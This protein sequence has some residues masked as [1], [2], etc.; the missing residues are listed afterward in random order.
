[1]E[2][3]HIAS[4]TLSLFFIVLLLSKKEKT[5]ADQ[6]LSVWFGIIFIHILTFYLLHNKGTHLGLILEISDSSAYLHAPLFWFYT[7]ALTQANFRFQWKDGWHF[8]PFLCSALLFIPN[9]YWQFESLEGLR[10]YGTFF[11]TLQILVYIIAIL[12]LLRQ[13]KKRLP[14]LFSSTE[15]VNLNWLQMLAWGLLAIWFISS[16]SLFLF[17]FLNVNIPYFGGFYTNLAISIFVF[18][19]GYFGFRQTTIFAPQHLISSPNQSKAT[20]STPHPDTA[21]K[22]Y[23][24]SGLNPTTA[25]QA[26]QELLSIMHHQQLYLNPQLTLQQL[27]KSLDIP[28]NHLSQIIN[29]Y[30]HLNFFDFVNQYRIEAVK[31]KFEEKVHLHHTLLAIALDCGF[32]SKASF[33]RAFKKFTEMTPTGYLKQLDA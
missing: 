15:K 28:P 18:I 23:A 4:G 7:L 9:F 27:A 5:I 33:N 32:N 29:A 10:T 20:P 17:F 8:L 6:I 12:I 3:L 2:V 16:I 30:A 21:T 13:H 25:E 14:D 24:K 22:K 11:K 26:F 1:M 31:K 19:M